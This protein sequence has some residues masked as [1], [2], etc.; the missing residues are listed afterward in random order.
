MKTNDPV[1]KYF[2]VFDVRIQTQQLLCRRWPCGQRFPLYHFHD[3]APVSSLS[4]PKLS[5]DSV[6]RPVKRLPRFRLVTRSSHSE[7]TVPQV[8]AG[9]GWRS[10]RCLRGHRLAGST[11]IMFEPNTDS[12]TNKTKSSGVVDCDW[13]IYKSICILV[14]I[15]SSVYLLLLHLTIPFILTNYNFSI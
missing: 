10:L 1:I 5:C 15:N 13:S 7:F 3:V 6:R 8:T 11:P 4:S 2:H 9:A 14:E 12:R